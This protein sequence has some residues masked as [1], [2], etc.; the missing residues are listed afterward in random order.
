MVAPSKNWTNIADTA[1]DADSPLDTT[2]MTGIRDNLV[3][4]KEWLGYGYTAAQAHKHDGVDSAQINDAD[5]IKTGKLSLFEDFMGVALDPR[6]GTVGT[7]SLQSGSNGI[8]KVNGGSIHQVTYPSFKLSSVQTVFETLVK[9]T[10]STSPIVLMGLADT[11]S[12]TAPT[13]AVYFGYTS[14]ASNW[15]CRTYNATTA[16]STDS[17][18][19]FNGTNWV[20]L[21][22]IATTSSVLFYIDDVLKATHTTNIPTANLGVILGNSASD[23]NVDYVSV[24]GPRG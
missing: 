14:S 1:I 18:V 12:L 6:W 23:H 2:L 10:G 11:T 20:K 13:N 15:W 8:V 21:K 9:I 24:V 22:I 4:I 17:G 3:N 19:A 16:T 7:I 5:I